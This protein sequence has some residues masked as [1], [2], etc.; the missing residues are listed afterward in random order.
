[1]KHRFVKKDGRIYLLLITQIWSE[2]AGNS[3]IQEIDVTDE[4]KNIVDITVKPEEDNFLNENYQIIDGVIT[5]V[6]KDKDRY[7]K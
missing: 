4:L 5:Y 7:Q 3:I 6:G 2:V 1:M